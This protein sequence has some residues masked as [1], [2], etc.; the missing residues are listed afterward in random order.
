MKTIFT[1]G[2]FIGIMNYLSSQE[3][4]PLPET[5]S[6]WI[7]THSI[8][9]WN[10]TPHFVITDIVNYCTQGIDTTINELTYFI[11]D[12]C[13]GGYKGAL[14]NDNGKVWF[15]PKNLQTEFLLYDFTAVPGDTISDVYIEGFFGY[16]ELYDLYVES[17]AVDSILIGE[18][19]RKRIN[20]EVGYW[21]E[22]IGNTQGLFLEPWPNV[23]DYSVDLYCMSENDTTLYPEFSIG[24]CES[25]VGINENENDNLQT[26]IYPNPFKDKFFVELQG[27]ISKLN[28]RNMKILNSVGQQINPV[29][30]VESDRINIEMGRFPAGIYLVILT[31][32]EKVY[33]R[34]LIKE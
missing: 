12:T 34:K 15:I 4:L 29:Y 9:E 23:S 6:K 5:N 30:H 7:N 32:D 26:T 17:N 1:I 13:D 19:Y 31:I 27:L 24:E 2:L 10:P 11:I 28:M 33:C 20:F 22:G 16:Y 18:T 3:Y 25:P 8:L 14:R 21:I